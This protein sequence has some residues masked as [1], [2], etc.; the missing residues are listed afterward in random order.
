MQ[1]KALIENII[2]TMEN[3]D[4]GATGLGHGKSTYGSPSWS[5]KCGQSKNAISPGILITRSSGPYGP[6][7]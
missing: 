1:Y 6:S 3:E 4:I 5:L 7:F 2:L